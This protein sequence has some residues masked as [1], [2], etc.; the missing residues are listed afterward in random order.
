M[1]ALLAHLLGAPLPLALPLAVLYLV[2]EGGQGSLAHHLGQVQLSHL[3]Q[4]DTW[5]N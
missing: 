4:K 1:D 5:V 3:T 2:P